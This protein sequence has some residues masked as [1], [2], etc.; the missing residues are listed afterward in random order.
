MVLRC[1]PDG[2][3]FEVLGHNFRNNYEPCIDSYGNI[4]Q[5]DNDDDGNASCRINFVMYYGNYGFLDEMTR[6]SWS[7]NRVG[8]E[9]TIPERHW[10][11]N[12]PGVVPNMLITGAGSPSGMTFYEGDLLSAFSNMPIHAEPYYN[13]VRAYVP[14]KKGA[15]YS[16]EIKDILKSDDQWF[17]P[18]DVSTAPDGSLFIA[19]WY[20]PILGGG[21]AGDAN[22]GRIY[23]VSPQ[24]DQYKVGSQDF[25]SIEGSMTALK[26]LT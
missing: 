5:S 26:I 10:H 18:V 13:V 9:E 21:A 17:R 22:R 14:I 24:A 16:A 23:R 19:D 20:D 1:D 7:T 3:N 12:D 15:G 8:L 6:A 25:N 11:Q 2:K 4:F